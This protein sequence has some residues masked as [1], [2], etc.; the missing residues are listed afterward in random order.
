MTCLGGNFVR[1]VCQRNVEFSACSGDLVHVDVLLGKSVNGFVSVLLHC[2]ASSMV[3][4]IL[5]LE[6]IWVICISVLHSKFW[7]RPPLFPP[8]CA[9]TV[10]GAS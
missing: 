10:F 3:L 5:K 9:G 4:E 2:N 7:V 1:A 6:K 8:M